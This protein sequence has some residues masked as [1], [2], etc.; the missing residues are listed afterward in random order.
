MKKSKKDILAEDALIREVT[1][2]VK[3]DQLR[4]LWNQ[5]GLFVIIF[6]ADKLYSCAKR[7]I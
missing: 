1:D 7:K 5:Y 2:D 4:Q 3:N 6:V